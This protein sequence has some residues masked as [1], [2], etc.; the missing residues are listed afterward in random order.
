LTSDYYKSQ[1][2]KPLVCLSQLTLFKLSTKPKRNN[3]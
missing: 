3:E 2:K 1:I